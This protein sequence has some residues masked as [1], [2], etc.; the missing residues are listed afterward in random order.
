M[1][2][3]LY[4]LE[5]KYGRFALPNLMLILMTGQA[6]VYLA[7]MLSMNVSISSMLS[8]YWPAVMQGQVWRL[9]TFVFVPLASTPF[10]VFIFL[11]CYYFIGHTVEQH[12]GDFRF[13]V[14]YLS[15]MLFAIL[16]AALTGYGTTNY[17][18]LSLFFIFA[19]LIPD[20]QMMLFFIIPVK[21]KY[22]SV[23]SGVICLVDFVRGSLPLRMAILMAL[24]NFL[25]FYGD[26]VFRNIKKEIQYSKT[27]KAWRNNQNNYRN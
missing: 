15:G 5:Y 8:L 1:M 20:A 24:A 10:L 22:L 17:L 27:R 23:F 11:Y 2:K 3:K 26:D 6:M 21:A 18:H 14:Y 19:A 9:V 12:W 16:G 25:L 13:N 7:D 4:K